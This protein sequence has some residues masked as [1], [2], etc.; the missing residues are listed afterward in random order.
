M[1]RATPAMEYDTERVTALA[2]K[3]GWDVLGPL[4][5]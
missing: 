5:A 1:W 2:V 3:H 4:M